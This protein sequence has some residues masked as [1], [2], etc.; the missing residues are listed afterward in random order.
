M[1]GFL[2]GTG[3]GLFGGFLGR[4][5]GRTFGGFAGRFL[6]GLVGG[7]GGRILR[8]FTRRTVCWCIGGIGGGGYGSGSSSG[9]SSRSGRHRGC[10]GCGW[11]H[12]QDG[13]RG[14]D[15]YDGSL[16]SSSGVTVGRGHEGRRTG[17]I[18]LGWSYIGGYII[19][20]R[21]LRTTEHELNAVDPKAGSTRPT[22]LT[23]GW[24]C[25][26]KSLLDTETEPF[27][28]IRQGITGTTRG[29]IILLLEL[30]LLLLWSW[31]WLTTT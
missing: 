1:G 28:T 26:T 2:G 6:G 27:D 13:Y 30:L 17:Q 9:G 29:T 19:I 31:W 20:R 24:L 7:I 23:T 25:T 8:G 11:C 10:G 21:Q 15:G 4:F 5:A 3:C 16:E 12:D 14:G 22:R 18:N